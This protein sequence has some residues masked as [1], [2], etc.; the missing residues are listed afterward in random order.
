MSQVA[1]DGDGFVVEATL[2]A[3]MFGIDAGQVQEDMRAGDITSTC[4]AGEGDDA[5]R[6]RL[7]FRRGEQACRLIVDDA[8]N[9]LQQARF[10]VRRRDAGGEGI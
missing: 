4:E 3:R 10:P 7:T 9:I 2:L 8:G 5:G 6:W 1:R